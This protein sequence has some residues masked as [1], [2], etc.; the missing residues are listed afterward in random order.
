MYVVLARPGTPLAKMP[1]TQRL[2]YLRTVQDLV[3]APYLKR[4]VRNV[5]EV[6]STGGYKKEFHVE[7]HPERLE[8][9]GIGIEDIAARLESIG[10]NFGGG[11]IQPGGKQVI[12]RTSGRL[13]SLDDIRS[14]PLKLDVL[15][16]PVPLGVVADV[17][18]DFAQRL[19]GAT[20]DGEQT[21]LGTVLMLSGANSREV[22]SDAEKALHHAPLPPDVQIKLLYSRSFL[23]NATLKTVAKNLAEGAVLVAVILLII[24]G[25]LRAAA[26]VCLAIPLSMFIG[27]LGMRAFGVSANLMSLGAIDFGLLVNGAVVMMENAFRRLQEH[28][29]PLAVE[30]RFQLVL[31]SAREV[32]KPVIL[33]LAIIMVVYV[34]LL[35]LEGIEGKLY[36]PMAITVLVALGASLLVAVFLMPVLAYF[37]LKIPSGH[38]EPDTASFRVLRRLYE[39]ILRMSLRFRW[40]PLLLAVV[41]VGIAGVVYF[42]LGADFMPLP[43]FTKL[44]TLIAP[45]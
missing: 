44:T 33:G 7:V 42:R 16:K 26:F 13:Q 9:Y 29:G 32:I 37:F 17:R 36:E 41:M 22:A 40:V 19:G 3:V 24:L 12:V 27:A 11:Y 38:K 21:V 23:V 14:L 30:A 20:Y 2:T 45:I 39:P 28:P 6:D 10:E 43:D 31:D 34:P 8:D 4:T 15:G 1:E 25:N 35:Y 18:E 5:A